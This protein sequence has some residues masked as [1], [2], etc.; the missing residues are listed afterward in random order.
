M[1]ASALD[2]ASGCTEPG[3][4]DPGRADPGRIEPGRIEPGRLSW[5]IDGQDWPN[6]GCSR[7][8]RAGGLV[9]HVQR[10]GT[11]PALLLLHGTGAATHSW[12][13]LMPLLAE[14]FTVVAPD[15]PGHGFTGMPPRHRL[16]LPDMSRQLDLLLRTLGIRPAYAVGHS[17]GAAIMAR[18]VLDRRIAPVA[19]M[20]LNGALQ[21]PPGVQAPLFPLMARLL[22]GLAPLPG[23]VARSAGQ[24]RI[25]RLLDGTGSRLDPAGRALYARLFR[26]PGHVAG[27]FGM[28][29]HWSLAP[30]RRELGRLR[31]PVTLVVGETDRMIPPADSRALL[32]VLPDVRLVSLPGLGH[33]AHEERPDQVA[34]L[35][36]A[37]ADAT[38]P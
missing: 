2:A 30:L 36:G 34:A 37:M 18:M 1:S 9:W 31:L 25:D 15:L 24:E 22:V 11:G 33:L 26:S 28:M 35:I 7:F 20:A 6:R 14:R 27:A 32:G 29:G 4:A 8:V 16:S 38:P 13:D 10:M 3:R 12:R 5:A 23:L 19:I 17:A 21:P